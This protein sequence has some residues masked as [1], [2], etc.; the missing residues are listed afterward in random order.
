[1]HGCRSTTSASHFTSP[2]RYSGF[3][4]KNHTGANTSVAIT[5]RN[6]MTVIGGNVS[7]AV[8]VAAKLV[9]QKSTAPRRQSSGMMR[10]AREDGTKGSG[11][12]VGRYGTPRTAYMTA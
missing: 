5:I 11:R 8:L 9:P 2:R 6:Q 4:R 12:S 1:M 7:S 10:L 3:G